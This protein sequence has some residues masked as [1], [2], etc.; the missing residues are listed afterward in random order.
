[1]DVVLWKAVFK[2][3]L[4]VESSDSGAVAAVNVVDPKLA[5]AAISLF[6]PCDLEAV[7]MELAS[8]FREM[9]SMSRFPF[10][11]KPEEILFFESVSFE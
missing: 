4:L 2:L 6:H 10:R 1:M 8:N 11:W 9:A 7:P 3:F 5:E